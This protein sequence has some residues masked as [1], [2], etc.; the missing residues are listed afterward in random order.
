MCQE[1]S[2]A[3]KITKKAWE[4]DTFKKALMADPHAAIEAEFGVQISKDVELK[5]I[6]QTAK[7]KYI[8]LPEKSEDLSDEQ[9]DSVS[10]GGCIFDVC[11]IN[12]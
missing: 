2:L 3:M 9:L 4:D 6:E 7:M 5:I 8:V 1:P 12:W 10:G 11:P